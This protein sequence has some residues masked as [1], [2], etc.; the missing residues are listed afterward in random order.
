MN[1]KIAFYTN[2]KRMG[3]AALIAAVLAG[4]S[5]EEQAAPVAANEAA[6]KE[7]KVAKVEKM[8]IGE[9]LEQV[10]DVVPSV[11]LDVPLKT[12]GDVLEIRKSRGD[13]VEK[14]EVILRLDPTDVLI[15]KE[16]AQIAITGTRQQLE[17][18][19]KDVA[20][21]KLELKNGIAK[22]EAALAE[23]EKSYN[24]LRND[25]DMG[26]VTD[27]QLEQMETQVNNLRLDLESSRQKLKTLETTNS[28]AQ[29]E[30]GL[31][32]A[33]VSIREADR[34]LEHMEVKAPVSGLLTELPVEVGM[35]LSPGFLAA[36]IQQLD[37][38]KIQAELTEEA[39]DLIR[40]KKEL[41]FYISGDSQRLTAAIS[42]LADVMSTQ[43][44][45][46]A[47]ELEFPN[48]DQKLRPGMKVQLLL[49]EEEDR[50]VVAVPTL[51][52]V[53]EGSETYVFVANGN[54]AEKRKIELGQ[55]DETYQEVIGG[56]EAGE[57]LIVSGQNQLKDQDTVQIAQ[58]VK[59]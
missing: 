24:K 48:A 54:T 23:T 59:E 13:T 5:A 34:T 2:V 6:V 17:K 4:C 55:I 7:V 45:T 31:Q 43:S 41:S 53:R 26:L 49:S 35:T 47:L 56:L 39:A 29:L 44:K 18:A 38:I 33:E 22:L 9:P 16:K 42:Y 20:D 37:P 28:L 25:Y 10:A 50:N 21:G 15:G 3:T 36:Q 46:Y 32:T 14:G 12:G 1:P 58:E 52:V 11:Q 51:S 8:I 57:Q 40:G 19:R 30:Q 27:F